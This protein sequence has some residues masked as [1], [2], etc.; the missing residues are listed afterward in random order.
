MKRSV[1][2]V[3]FDK[4]V[5]T[6][7]IGQS[8]LERFQLSFQDS[9]LHKILHSVTHSRICSVT[10]TPHY[11]DEFATPTSQCHREEPTNAQLT[12]KS[13]NSS[14]VAKLNTLKKYER[15]G[16]K[17]HIIFLAL[18]MVGTVDL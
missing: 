1:V 2:S 7:P 12:P 9:N 11:F 13:I 3:E 10:D 17:T 8:L 15:T 16:F 14:G 5:L 4:K 18:V 6:A